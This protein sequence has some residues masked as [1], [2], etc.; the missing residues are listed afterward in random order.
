MLKFSV[1]GTLI[2]MLHIAEKLL[3]REVEAKVHLQPNKDKEVQCRSYTS[4]GPKQ[5]F[6]AR[7]N[8][9]HFLKKVYKYVKETPLKTH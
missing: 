8:K 7:C 3:I 4:R 9:L 6:F 1:S 5:N 2:K